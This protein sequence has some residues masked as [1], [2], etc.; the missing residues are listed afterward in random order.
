MKKVKAEDEWKKLSEEVIAGTSAWREK[1][2]WIREFRHE[3][4]HK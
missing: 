1:L 3:N 4:G 2:W